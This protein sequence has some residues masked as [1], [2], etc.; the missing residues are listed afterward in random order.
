MRRP[1]VLALVLLV[2]AAAC[3]DDPPG[4]GATADEPSSPTTGTDQVRYT[5]TAMVM[6]APGRGVQLCLGGVA[7]SLPPQC[8]GLDLVGWDWEAVDGE[9]SASGSTW[10]TYTV[11]G[12][13][14][15]EAQ[16]FTLTEPARSPEPATTDP[17]PGVDTTSPCPPPEGG[18]QVVDPQTATDEAMS[19]AIEHARAQP[20]V[21]GVWVDQSINPAANAE[22][23][24]EWAMND[25][26][27]L[28][29]NISFTGDLDRHEA[30][31]RAIWGGALCISE[32]PRSAADLL[33]IRQEVEGEVGEHLG[34]WSDEVSG[35]IH[36]QVT[37]D[38]GL[39]DR[40]DE[41]YGAG[42][43]VV[44]PALVPVS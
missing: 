11:V 2:L 29:L 35:T 36:V 15:G 30:E 38:D 26:E 43:V 23:V 19:A 6:D 31:I 25:P 42:A 7:E 3:G 17:D 22:V 32:A 21:G 33:T 44:V 4:E 41:R 24:D 27:R 18:W 20:D 10:G 9:E 12:T 16:S 14:D 34:S 39:Q 1:I 8:G 5:A 28:V 13:Y 37:V 40:F